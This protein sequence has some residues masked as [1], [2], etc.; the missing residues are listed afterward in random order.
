MASPF[1]GMD[2]YLEDH[3]GDIH[4]ALI[5][6]MRDE[7]SR[8]VPGDLRVR[9][10]EY[11]AVEVDEFEQ[12]GG[13]YPDVRVI[14]RHAATGHSLT[15][16]SAAA[17]ATPYVVPLQLEPPTQREIRIIDKRSNDRIVTAI[18]LLS[19]TNK[20][21]GRQDYRRK[22]RQFLDSETN[23]V[24][25]DLLRDGAWVI[26]AP[27]DAVPEVCRGPYRICVT[28][29][30]QPRECRLFEASYRFPLPTFAIPLRCGDPT[31]TL[32]LQ[33]LLQRAYETGRYDDDIDYTLEPV[34]GL[35]PAEA[36][37][38]DELLRRAGRR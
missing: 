37:W 6:Y 2:P 32:D 7:L 11:V 25:I 33:S 35:P 31:V 18:E 29:E 26:A 34:P 22:Q 4:A 36:Q 30:G 19:P 24:E 16:E 12:L 21:R 38:A 20:N 10:E 15:A 23:L 9:V 28:P 14:E 5:G 27:I 3:W 1:P 8:Q 13:F 17:V